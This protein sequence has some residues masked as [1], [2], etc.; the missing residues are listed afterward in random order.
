METTALTHVVT[1]AIKK[2]DD[3]W[4]AFDSA[5][6]LRNGDAVH[7]VTQRP[8]NSR[9]VSELAEACNCSY[10]TAYSRMRKGVRIGKLKEMFVRIPDRKNRLTVTRVFV[11]VDEAGE[12]NAKQAKSNGRGRGSRRRV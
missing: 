5:H 12:A 11:P 7:V 3:F 9:T 1:Q 10:N 8:S 4:S 2:H 6:M